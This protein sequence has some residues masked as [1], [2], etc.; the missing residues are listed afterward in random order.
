MAIFIMTV[1]MPA[2]VYNAREHVTA[3]HYE[4]HKVREVT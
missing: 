1:I 4:V 3:G 2:V